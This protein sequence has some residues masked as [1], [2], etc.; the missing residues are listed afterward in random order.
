M[1]TGIIKTIGTVTSIKSTKNETL[2]G[3]KTDRLFKGKKMSSSI[4]V[5]GVCLTITK[6]DGNKAFFNLMTETL[7]ATNLKDI[8]VGEKVNIE[9]ALTFGQGLDGHLVQGHVDAEGE[10]VEIRKESKQTTLRI[11]YPRNFCIFL[12]LKGSIAINGVS[13]TISFLE[14]GFFEVCLVD[15]TLQNT[16]LSNL[17]KGDKV[18]LEFDAI[19]KY[20]K[21]LLDAKES[22]TKYEFLKD[23]GF[24]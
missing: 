24:I 5:N 3:I 15:H 17:K 14:E 21:S 7:K 12:S 6:I 11:S 9:P 23:R 1:F 10:I 20:L 19:A 16:N 4:A 2:I 13:L 18:N 8:K 22:E